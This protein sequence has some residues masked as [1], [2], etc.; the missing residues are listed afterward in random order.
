MS[1]SRSYYRAVV[2]CLFKCNNE[3]TVCP[4]LTKLD[5]A[6]PWSLNNTYVKCEADEMNSS[7][8]ICS[9]YRQTEISGIIKQMN[10]LSSMLNL[11]RSHMLQLQP[12]LKCAFCPIDFGDIGYGYVAA[13]TSVVHLCVSCRV[14][15]GQLQGK[16]HSF[17]FVCDH[18]CFFLARTSDV[19]KLVSGSFLQ[20]TQPFVRIGNYFRFSQRN[21]LFFG[22]H[23]TF[24][25]T[26][27]QVKKFSLFLN[28]RCAIEPLV[29]CKQKPH[30]ISL[31]Q[32]RSCI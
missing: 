12:I 6:L 23:Y 7:Q 24:N 25:L 16:P 29:C 27:S 28:N 18:L 3:H 5:N 15:S 17:S 21:F 30:N 1:P 22:C 8:G 19:H 26:V 32:Y 20:C 2:V 10:I 31:K 13:A 9:E 14:T 11:S 4:N